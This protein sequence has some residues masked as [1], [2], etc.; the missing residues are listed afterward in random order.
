MTPSNLHKKKQEDNKRENMD[1]SNK[2]NENII[3]EMF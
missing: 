3:K 1:E 2:L